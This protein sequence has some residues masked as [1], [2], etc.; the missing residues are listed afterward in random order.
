MPGRLA[1]AQ[2][3]ERHSLI[4][5]GDLRVAQRQSHQFGHGL[6][7]LIGIPARDRREQRSMIRHR[8]ARQSRACAACTGLSTQ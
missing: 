5:E 6:P 4:A 8:V 2:C 3:P 1:S 7:G